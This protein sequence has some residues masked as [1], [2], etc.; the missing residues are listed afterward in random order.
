MKDNSYELVR[1]STE[2]HIWLNKTGTFKNGGIESGKIFLN[3]G[4]IFKGDF[5]TANSDVDVIVSNEFTSEF[6]MKDNK[7]Y[8]GSGCYK[9]LYNRTYSGEWV[10]GVFEGIMKLRNGV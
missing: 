10:D 1:D 3:N 6:K 9:D 7:L 8:T 2:K 4:V 5:A